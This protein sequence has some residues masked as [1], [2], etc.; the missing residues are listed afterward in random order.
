MSH[1]VRINSLQSSQTIYKKA[2]VL[3]I[4]LGIFIFCFG[5]LFFAL[6]TAWLNNAVFSHGFFVSAI[7]LYLVWR[8][9]EDLKQISICPNIIVGL[10]VLIAGVFLYVAGHIGGVFFAEELS[11]IITLTGMV[12]FV[13][14]NKF[15]KVLLFP[16]LYLV[17][18]LTSW[19]ILTERLHMP[20]QIFSSY[21]GTS[22]LYTIGIPAY[23]E[24]IF[25]ELP[26]IKLEVAKVCSGVNY[27]VAVAAIGIPLA[28][29]TIRSWP[30]RFILVLSSLFMAML[31]N[32]FRVALI[33]TL[34]YY[35]MSGDMHGPYHTLHAMIVSIAGYAVLF[36]GAWLLSE[37]AG[38]FDGK[39][40]NN[41]PAIIVP[42]G[43]LKKS[44][45]VV[46]A[47]VLLLAGTYINFHSSTAV[48]PKVDLKY[49]PG[50][51]GEW[52]IAAANS[53]R[54]FANI[55]I[56]EEFSNT[57]VKPDGAEA[58]LSI[59][60]F[61]YQGYGKK[62]INSLTENL[63]NAAIKINIDTADGPIEVNRTI[64]GKRVILFFYDMNGRILADKYMVKAYTALDALVK[65]KTSG[66]IIIVTMKFP[67]GYMATRGED[68]FIRAVVPL[69]RS[70]VR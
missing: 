27:L 41:T 47:G 66:A 42:E 13:L 38:P 30:R 21:I 11:L 10:F 55:K 9:K 54:T 16:I 63:H 48:K 40:D 65:G 8:R 12:M 37:K 50:H 14:G 62:L 4:L 60:Y 25:I 58:E 20:F 59:G 15:L 64:E 51:I 46:A 57:Y 56:D 26:N 43:K 52:T 70:H 29:M 18:M 28:Y 23:R 19:G 32:G 2:R 53:S 7:S 45:V 3:F 35:N 68:E 67:D 34:A 44:T 6:I 1:A 22:L 24:S 39:P 31:A 61:E 49:F 5:K 69:I 36:I 17:F 33:G